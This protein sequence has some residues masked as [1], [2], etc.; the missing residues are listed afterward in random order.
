MKVSR[1][2]YTVMMVAFATFAGAVMPDTVLLRFGTTGIDIQVDP[3]IVAESPFIRD[4]LE[5]IEASSE[6]TQPSSSS[7]SPSV[8]AIPVIDIPVRGIR[9]PTTS[10][11]R[12]VD[13]FGY[14]R[15]EE[16]D[17]INTLVTN[18]TLDEQLDLVQLYSYLGA[19]ALLVQPLAEAVLASFNRQP[20]ALFDEDVV[21]FDEKGDVFI[22][23]TSQIYDFLRLG[24][25]QNTFT[26]VNTGIQE[27]L[28]RGVRFATLSPDARY[29]LTSQTPISLNPGCALYAFNPSQN[30]ALSL[31]TRL[32]NA[33]A[34]IRPLLV[35]GNTLSTYAIATHA[36]RNTV[37]IYTYNALNKSATLTASTSSISQNTV[38]GLNAISNIVLTGDYNTLYAFSLD[39]PLTA[40]TPPLF[41]FP[42]AYGSSPIAFNT[43]GTLLA[44]GSSQGVRLYTYDAQAQTFTLTYQNTALKVSSALSLS[45]D[46]RLLAVGS[47][48]GSV[49]LFELTEDYQAIQHGVQPREMFT[50][51]IRALALSSDGA[52]LAVVDESGLARVYTYDTETKNLKK[53]FEQQLAGYVRSLSLSADGLYLLIAGDNMLN[54]F[55]NN[56]ID[57]RLLNIAR[58]V[59]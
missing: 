43:D 49:A 3:R 10:F 20:D 17:Q 1:I 33:Q 40:N 8:V 58:S 30:P 38:V 44:V 36:T 54:V 9:S 57:Y 19:P 4:A 53:I 16:T 48:N 25:T 32:P 59:L 18:A 37:D 26:P 11:S 51:T 12:M 6:D 47:A 46:G 14:A 7:S 13:A 21:M 28:L 22:N 31:I 55:Q 42:D 2:L 41:I 35:P 27:Q 15:P 5:L 52:Y 45:A 34:T 23:E 50:D 39:T 24:L 29:I 56:T